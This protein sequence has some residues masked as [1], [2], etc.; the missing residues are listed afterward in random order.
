LKI[1]AVIPTCEAKWNAGF[2]FRS[3]PELTH[4]PDEILVVIDGRK[5]AVEEASLAGVPVRLTG[6]SLQWVCVS[7]FTFLVLPFS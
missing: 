7:I 4:K 6:S 2:T 5:E 1:S 3:L